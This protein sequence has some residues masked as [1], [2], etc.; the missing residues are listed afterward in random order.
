MAAKGETQKPRAEKPA[1][2]EEPEGKDSEPIRFSLD[3]RLVSLRDKAL[4]DLQTLR[5]VVRAGDIEA[6]RHIDKAEKHLRAAI[7]Q[8]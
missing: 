7:A 5:R 4:R 6:H 1:K 8:I 2:V 3:L